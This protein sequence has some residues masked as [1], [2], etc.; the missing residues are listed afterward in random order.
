MPRKPVPQRGA[1]LGLPV[2]LTLQTMFRRIRAVRNPRTTRRPSGAP[3]LLGVV[4]R[5]RHR[6]RAIKEKSYNLLEY[7]FPDTHRAVDAIAWLH[8]IHF[9]HSDLPWLSFSAIA[10]L[11]VE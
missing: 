3:M 6:V 4:L 7:F 10:E 8:P 2:L 11:D 9:A 1:A 5:L